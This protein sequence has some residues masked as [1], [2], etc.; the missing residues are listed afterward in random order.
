MKLLFADICKALLSLASA[1]TSEVGRINQFLV[2]FGYFSVF[3]EPCGV[4]C[5]FLDRY[6]IHPIS[7]PFFEL[8][9]AHAIIYIAS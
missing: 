1:P 7:P 3:T 9:L 8:S 5:H 2:N 6:P 4:M